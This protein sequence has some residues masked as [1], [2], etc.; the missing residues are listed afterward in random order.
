MAL[1]SV[2]GI[3]REITLTSGSLLSSPSVPY[4]TPCSW[5]GQLVATTKVQSPFQRPECVQAWR[6]TPAGDKFH[7]K[8]AWWALVGNIDA[9]P[10]HH[11]KNGCLARV[12][13][14]KGNEKADVTLW[15]S[16]PLVHF[17]AHAPERVW[18]SIQTILGLVINFFVI[19]PPSWRVFVFRPSF[20]PS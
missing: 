5:D 14:L 18:N 6:V 3:G 2:A 8:L 13:T 10:F 16:R 15:F 1:K 19:L 17:V 9:E 11:D 7:G 20:D 12:C 4:G